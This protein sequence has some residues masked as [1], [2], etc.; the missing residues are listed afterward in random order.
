MRSKSNSSANVKPKLLATVGEMLN[1]KH[2]YASAHTAEGHYSGE[3]AVLL[4]PRIPPRRKWEKFPASSGERSVG[5]SLSKRQMCSMGTPSFE[6]G[7]FVTSKLSR[8]V[9]SRGTPKEAFVKRTLC[10]LTYSIIERYSRSI[11]TK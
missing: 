8:L 3:G 4:F 1:K 7:M 2:R 9:Q 11:C 5:D 10:G 6:M